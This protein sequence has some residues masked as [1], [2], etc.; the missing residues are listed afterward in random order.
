LQ[1]LY[2]IEK[3]VAQGIGVGDED[4]SLKQGVHLRQPARKPLGVLQEPGLDVS[5]TVCARSN[6]R[7]L[8]AVQTSVCTVVG[9]TYNEETVQ[10][11]KLSFCSTYKMSEW[12][13]QWDDRQD[14]GEAGN[15]AVLWGA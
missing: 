4:G 14:K 5:R 13:M 11:S 7:C 2:L 15:A 9:T 3:R 12:Q 6:G 1:T 10:A 8:T